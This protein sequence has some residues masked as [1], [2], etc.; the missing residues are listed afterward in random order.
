MLSLLV[1]GVYSCST[2]NSIPLD[3]SKLLTKD[4]LKLVKKPGYV[5]IQTYGNV[6]AQMQTFDTSQACLAGVQ[7]FYKDSL[8]SSSFQHCWTGRLSD[9]LPHQIGYFSNTSEWFSILTL[10]NKYSQVKIT[11]V[12]KE[13]DLII[14]HLSEIDTL[15]DVQIVT[16]DSTFFVDHEYDSFSVPYFGTENYRLDSAYT[17]PSGDKIVILEIYAGDEQTTTHY[18]K[19]KVW[20][21]NYYGVVKSMSYLNGHF[22]DESYLKSVIIYKRNKKKMYTLNRT[23][24]YLIDTR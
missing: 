23:Y 8:M 18:A 20:V 16:V 5:V 17:G 4:Y 9:T 13:F 10:M 1:V 21:S 22:T 12:A 3:A 11:N 14:P 19:T 24:N 2:Y 7:K 6:Q 15:S